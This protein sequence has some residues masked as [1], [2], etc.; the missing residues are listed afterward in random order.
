MARPE[1]VQASYDP[2]SGYEAGLALADDPSV[3][4]VLCGNDELAIGVMRAFTE[5][6]RRVPDDV[7]VV[8][9]DDQPFARMWSPPLTT[10][11]Q[12]F[13]ELGRRTFEMLA[14]WVETGCVPRTRRHARPGG[15]RARRL[16]EAEEPTSAGP[17]RN[18]SIMTPA[19]PLPAASLDG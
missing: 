19:V 17:G 10:V 9:F 14:R 4:A 11:A 3:T 2:D 6:G 18:V 15:P 16:L 8:G 5:R 13:V 7:S 1:V 12:D